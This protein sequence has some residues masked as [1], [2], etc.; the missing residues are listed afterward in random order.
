MKLECD[1]ATFGGLRGKHLVSFTWGPRRWGD[2]LFHWMPVWSHYEETTEPGT[3]NQKTQIRSLGQTQTDNTKTDLSI[4]AWQVLVLLTLCVRKLHQHD[5]LSKMYC[6]A[7]FKKMSS[8]INN[9]PGRSHPCV[10]QR[11]A[12]SV[13][14]FSSPKEPQSVR[15]TEILNVSARFP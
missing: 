12:A 13:S 7:Y 5:P 9:L 3:A 4:F 2:G 11:N 14:N 6:C 10:T 8:E 15:R 1:T